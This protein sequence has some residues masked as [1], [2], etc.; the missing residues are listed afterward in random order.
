M[1]L[2]V[3]LRSQDAL[4]SNTRSRHCRRK[5]QQQHQRRPPPPRRPRRVLCSRAQ[6]LIVSA[7]TTNKLSL[8]KRARHNKLV[9]LGKRLASTFGRGVRAHTHAHARAWRTTTAAAAAATLEADG[10]VRRSAEDYGE[11]KA[12]G[13]LALASRAHN[14]SA[15]RRRRVSLPTPPSSSSW[16]D[17]AAAAATVWRGDGQVRGRLAGRVFAASP[18]PRLARRPRN[19]ESLACALNIANSR[20][21]CVALMRLGETTR[22]DA[23]RRDTQGLPRRAGKT[24][25]GEPRA[26]ACVARLA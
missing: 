21:K 2:C 14:V 18:W 4:K 26:R 24:A 25:L 12:R 15:W 20:F 8:P 7:V 19:A 1:R 13:K 10:N 16:S 9:E 17:A 3:E 22:H 23:T 5:Q 6:T 11:C